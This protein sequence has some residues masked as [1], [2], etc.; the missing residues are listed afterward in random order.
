MLALVGILAVKIN[1]L[2][3]FKRLGTQI[4]TYLVFWYIV[5]FITVACGATNFGL[6]DYKCIFGSYK[7]IAMTC[8]KRQ[9]LRRYLDFQIISVVLDV[10]SDVLSKSHEVL[11]IVNSANASSHFFPHHHTMER[12]HQSPKEADSLMHIWLGRTDYCGHC[13]AW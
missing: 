10:F 8:S 3:F 2:L 11:F 9:S 4:T 6:I 5:L 13:C 7:Y 12:A 1:F